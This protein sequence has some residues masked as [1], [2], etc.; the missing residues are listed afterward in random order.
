MSTI[1]NPMHTTQHTH[2]WPAPGNTPPV[3]DLGP[4]AD[5]DPRRS[6][7]EYMRPY[8]PEQPLFQPLRCGR[9]ILSVQPST[10]GPHKHSCSIDAWDIAVFDLRGAWLGPTQLPEMFD[11]EIW[12]HFFHT[13]GIG[14]AIPQAVAEAIVDMLEFGPKQYYATRVPHPHTTP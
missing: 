8:Y 11:D 3:P 9:F 2:A 5:Y 1:P 7:E 4:P 14:R 13:D 10:P 12:G 6:F